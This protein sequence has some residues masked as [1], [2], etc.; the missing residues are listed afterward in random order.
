[1]EGG[2]SIDIKELNDINYLKKYNIKNTPA[3]VIN[4]KKVSEGKVLTS[5]EICKILTSY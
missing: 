2:I 3:L 1:M 4:G 5:R